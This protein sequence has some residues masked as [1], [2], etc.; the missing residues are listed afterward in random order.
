MKRTLTWAALAA[1]TLAAQAPLAGA[2][3]IFNNF[4]PGNDFGNGGRVVDGGDGVA[5][6]GDIDQAVAFTVGPADQMAETL[7]LGIFVND[8]PAIGTGPVDIILAMDSGDGPGAALQTYSTTVNATGKQ[9]LNVSGAP[10]LLSANTTYWVVMDAEDEFRGSWNFNTIGDI[11]LT[12]GRTDLGIW[13]TRP[14]D[15]RMA[16]RVEGRVPE[17]A[18]LAVLGIGGMVIAGRRR[19]GR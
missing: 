11:G 1:L 14:L 13:G 16:L 15:D 3:V 19:R 2:A 10:V 4:G 9:V 5:A 7:S 6:I 17:P 8:S 12:A 18:S